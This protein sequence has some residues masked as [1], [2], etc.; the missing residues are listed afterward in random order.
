MSLSPSEWSVE[1]ITL[2]RRFPIGPHYV[3]KFRPVDS[4]DLMESVPAS[5]LDVVVYLD[6]SAVAPL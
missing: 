4:G 2:V 6:G 5:F 3:V 1:E